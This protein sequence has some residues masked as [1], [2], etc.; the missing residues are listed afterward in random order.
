MLD[1]TQRQAILTLH[2]QGLGKRAIARTLQISRNTVREV[3]ADGR[4][5]PPPLDRA[6]QLEPVRDEILALF[7]DCKGNLVRGSSA[8][9]VSRATMKAG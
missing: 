6:E 7:A 4:A 2:D 3:L 5:A 8:R 9:S 1:Q